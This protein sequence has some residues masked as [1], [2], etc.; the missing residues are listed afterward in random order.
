MQNQ[1]YTFQVAAIN[2][3]GV[4]PYSDPVSA[5]PGSLIHTCKQSILYATMVVSK[6]FVLVL[7][8]TNQSMPHMY[9][10]GDSECA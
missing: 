1:T 10:E 3:Y 8:W 6:V 5:T 7:D 4:G 9:M 2:G